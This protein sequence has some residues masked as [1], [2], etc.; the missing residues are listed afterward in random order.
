[1]AMYRWARQSESKHWRNG[2]R[3]QHAARKNHPRA[4]RRHWQWQEVCRQKVR[5]AEDCAASYLVAVTFISPNGNN[6]YPATPVSGLALVWLFSEFARLPASWSSKGHKSG[7]LKA[8][9]KRLPPRWPCR[10]NFYGNE[11][12]FLT[13]THRTSSQKNLLRPRTQSITGESVYW[14]KA[15]EWVFLLCHRV[16]NQPN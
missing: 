4:L 5:T 7:R 14:A 8:W 16:W 12:S 10:A 3:F 13:A 9:S 2:V 6:Q 1:M 11:M 15:P